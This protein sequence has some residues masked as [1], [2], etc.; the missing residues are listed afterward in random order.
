MAREWQ[1]LFPLG[2]QEI[3]ALEK[4]RATGQYEQRRFEEMKIRADRVRFRSPRNGESSRDYQID[5]ESAERR[6]EDAQYRARVASGPR[7]FKELMGAKR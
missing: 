6:F 5:L 1:G 2:K 7:S 3:A 4:R